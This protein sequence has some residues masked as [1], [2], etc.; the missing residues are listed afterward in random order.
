MNKEF[1]MVNKDLGQR[2]L[3]YAEKANAVA[4]DQYGCHKKH[5]AINM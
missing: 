3:A 5:K 2:V 1:N 4:P